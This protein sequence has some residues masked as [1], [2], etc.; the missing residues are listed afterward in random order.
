MGSLQEEDLILGLVLAMTNPLKSQPMEK[1]SSAEKE[2]EKEEGSQPKRNNKRK[3][4]RPATKTCKKVFTKPESL[5]QV[6]LNYL[7]KINRDKEGDSVKRNEESSPVKKKMKNDNKTSKKKE[8]DDKKIE[9]ESIGSY[10]PKKLPKTTEDK[11]KRKVRIDCSET[12]CA[13][14]TSK[15]KKRCLVCKLSEHECM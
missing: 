11:I 1:K 8:N 9:K 3:A 6:R 7:S 12:Y 2:S 10:I 5:I 14:K 4:E 15:N 13:E